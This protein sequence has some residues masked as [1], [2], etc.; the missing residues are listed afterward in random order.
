ML[1]STGRQDGWDVRRDD[2]ELRCLRPLL[3]PCCSTKLACCRMLAFSQPPS[4][5]DL[6]A[7]DRGE[8]QWGAAAG[9]V[10]GAGGGG[11]GFQA[12]VGVDNVVVNRPVLH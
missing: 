2:S 3:Y 7:A 6:S 9:A 1:D 5:E 10:S 11:A 8:E 4:S 12:L